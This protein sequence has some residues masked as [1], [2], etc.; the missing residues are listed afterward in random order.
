[1]ILNVGCGFR[2]IGDVNVDI[3]L[4]C[5][6]KADAHFLPFRENS[7]KMVLLH[8]VLEH[9]KE[10][11]KALD[12]I[13]RVGK[14]VEIRTPISWHPYGHFDK[15]HLWFFPSDWFRK[16]ARSR[17]LGISGKLRFDPDRTFLFL[18]VELRVYL[19]KFEEN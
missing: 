6:L 3:K 7:F 2:L 14:I 19:H 8:H 13:M 5:D 1:M 16:Y 15:T 12:E 4:P 18:A 11:I 17:K 9:L 10:P